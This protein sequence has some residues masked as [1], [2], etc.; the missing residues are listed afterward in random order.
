ML[1]G[2]MFRVSGILWFVYVIVVMCLGFFEIVVL[3]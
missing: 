2:M 1:I 3:L